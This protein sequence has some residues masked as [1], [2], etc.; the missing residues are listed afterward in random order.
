MIQEFP[1]TWWILSGISTIIGD[2][3]YDTPGTYDY[4]FENT[5]AFPVI[6]PDRRRGIVPERLP[7]NRKTCIDLRREYVYCLSQF[8]QI[9]KELIDS[10]CRFTS[11]SFQHIVFPPY[12]RG[13]LDLCLPDDQQYLRF[14]L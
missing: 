4:V 2:S 10:S 3:A 9:A 5:P 11:D 13:F 7:V 1:M 14:S 6:D 8:W 12:Y